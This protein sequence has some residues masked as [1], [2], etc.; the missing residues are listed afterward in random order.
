V[1]GQRAPLLL[2]SHQASDFWLGQIVCF[3]K[4]IAAPARLRVKERHRRI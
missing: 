1:N 3:V 2:H 4:G